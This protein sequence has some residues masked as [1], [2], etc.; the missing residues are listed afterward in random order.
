[1]TSRWRPYRGV[2]GEALEPMA[3]QAW[4]IALPGGGSGFC[5]SILHRGNTETPVAQQLSDDVSCFT[6]QC[7][8]KLR[9]ITTMGFDFTRLRIRMGFAIRMCQ[10]LAI[11]ALELRSVMLSWHVAYPGRPR[12]G[13][14]FSHTCRM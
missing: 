2:E 10:Y 9:C 8:F 1:M 12:G 4:I 6:D 13:P 5:P 7:G 14:R 11:D 3:H